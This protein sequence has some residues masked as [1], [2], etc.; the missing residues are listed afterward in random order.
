MNFDKISSLKFK[1]G[2]IDITGIDRLAT[3]SIKIQFFCLNAIVSIKFLKL[4]SPR[5]WQAGL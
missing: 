5:T 3:I 1:G 4:F 2:G